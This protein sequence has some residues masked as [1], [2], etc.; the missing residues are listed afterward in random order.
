MDAYI[1]KEMEKCKYWKIPQKNH[2]IML[3]QDSV[4]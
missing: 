3:S 1:S 2:V 4:I